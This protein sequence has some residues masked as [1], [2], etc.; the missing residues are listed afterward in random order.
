M[1]RASTKRNDVHAVRP[2]YRR[3]RHTYSKVATTLTDIR[4]FVTSNFDRLL[5]F[6]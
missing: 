6:R 5:R 1:Y 3:V 4:V 2:L